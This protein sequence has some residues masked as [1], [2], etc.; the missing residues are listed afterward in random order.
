MS[1]FKEPKFPLGCI[2]STISIHKRMKSDLIFEEF[3]RECL[4]RH[5]NGDWGELCDED[6][7]TNEEGLKYGERLMSAYHYKDN[8]E[9]KIWIITEWDRSTT[10]ILYPSEY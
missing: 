7:A 2:V 5:R 8:P 3:V 9:D 4:D 6:K 10:T 1:L